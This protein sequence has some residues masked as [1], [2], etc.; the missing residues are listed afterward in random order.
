MSL[1]LALFSARLCYLAGVQ[2]PLFPL[3]LA[4]FPGMTLPLH[5]FEERYKKMV[6]D[7]VEQNQRRFVIVLA[8]PAVDISDR[9]AP[10]YDVGSFVDILT[11]SENP[12]GTY[13]MLAHGQER[14]KVRVT[15]R[16]SVQEMDGSTRGLLYTA[17]EAYPLGR[18]DPNL[19]RV[20][21]WDA[22]DTFREY[23]RTFFTPDAAEQIDEALPDD[24]VYQASF[25]CA[26][27]RVPVTSRQVMLEAPSLTE[28]FNVAQRLMQELLQMS[29]AS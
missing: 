22:L 13:D 27:L 14:C 11:V 17:E 1:Y 18:G 16:E 8:K 25:I 28:R 10:L 5:I 9:D 21:A 4:V 20:A 2:L 23:A 6:R 7:C 12:D 3:S 24:L 15:E 29:R 26:N 19:E